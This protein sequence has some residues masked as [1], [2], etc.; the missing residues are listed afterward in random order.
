MRL[1]VLLHLH[2]SKEK[3]QLAFKFIEKGL[4]GLPEGELGGIALKG[5]CEKLL[6]LPRGK[7]MAGETLRAAASGSFWE[8]ARE[9]KGRTQRATADIV[10][11]G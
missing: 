9:A 6:I 5:L 7:P 1:G 3:G 2:C 10:T 4:N 11:D 8:R